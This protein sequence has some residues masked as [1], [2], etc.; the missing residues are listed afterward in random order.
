MPGAGATPTAV[1]TRRRA[2]TN[3]SPA[4]PAL[5]AAA[6]VKTKSIQKGF[7]GAVSDDDD[8]GGR[9]GGIEV[10]KEKLL[11]M[12]SRLKTLEEEGGRMKDELQDLR[13]R[14]EEEKGARGRLEE[15]LAEMERREPRNEEAESGEERERRLKGEIEAA[16]KRLE[17]KLDE[18]KKGTREEEIAD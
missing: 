17:K 18:T 11:R 9:Y 12:E 7:R 14:L 6:A 13:N 10:W 8:D 5:K 4:S 15:R 16:E 3:P 2:A 1:Q